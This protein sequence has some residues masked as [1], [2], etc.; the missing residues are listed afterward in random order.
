MLILHLME[1]QIQA[2]DTS[3][4][5]IIGRSCFRKNS[6][7]IMST[8][9]AATPASASLKTPP[10]QPFADTG[11]DPPAGMDTHP[12]WSA[13]IYSPLVQPR[14]AKNLPSDRGRS[15]FSMH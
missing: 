3:S 9:R 7:L 1:R 4:E 11:R 5:K 2:E 12:G 6:F 8:R 13:D 14:D 15:F 10:I